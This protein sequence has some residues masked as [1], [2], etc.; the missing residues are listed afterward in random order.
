M[1]QV[2]ELKYQGVGRAEA[3]SNCG[4]AGVGDQQARGIVFSL[5]RPCDEQPGARSHETVRVASWACEYG[6]PDQRAQERIR[7]GEAADKEVSC[8]L[9]VLV[10]RADSLQFLCVDE[11]VGLTKAVQTGNNKDDPTSVVESG[12]K[13][14][15]E[16]EAE[17][18]S[19][20]G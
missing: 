12:R 4:Q 18:S 17:V 7:I 8:K 2:A 14:S 10:D 20:I 6:E 1:A 16:R 5:S 9:G 3:V 13:D 15:Q 19:D 11:E